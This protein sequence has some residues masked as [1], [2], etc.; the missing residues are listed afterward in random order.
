MAGRIVYLLGR[1][2]YFWANMFIWSDDLFICSLGL[3]ITDFAIVRYIGNKLGDIIA[4]IYNFMRSQM[5]KMIIELILPSQ[6]TYILNIH[7]Q[8]YSLNLHSET[9]Y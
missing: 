7:K 2:V 3:L 8:F 4:F 1:F 6:S 5:N 9:S